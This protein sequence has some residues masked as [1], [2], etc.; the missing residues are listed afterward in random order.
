MVESRFGWRDLGEPFPPFLGERLF[1]RGVDGPSV[2]LSAR[3]VEVREA[4]G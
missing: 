4:A 2:L 1:L 3:G